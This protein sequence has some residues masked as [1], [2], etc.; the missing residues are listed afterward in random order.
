MK[1]TDV[2][3]IKFP[4]GSYMLLWLVNP[5]KELNPDGSFEQSICS[6][7]FTSLKE[8]EETAE[9]LSGSRIILMCTAQNP[10]P[11]ANVYW[12]MVKSYGNSFNL[13]E[14]TLLPVNLQN[15]FSNMGKLRSYLEE[16]KSKN[17]AVDKGQLANRFNLNIN[18][19][20]D[21]ANSVYFQ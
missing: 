6:Q 5:N 7:F 2:S 10:Q 12:N 16:A 4:I 20:N 18:Q 15:S 17:W 9:Y 8:A 21:I 14:L 1:T 11:D 13:N 3:S 19:V